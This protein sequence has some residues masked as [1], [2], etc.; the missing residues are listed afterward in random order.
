[1]EKNRKKMRIFIFAAIHILFA[2][3]LLASSNKNDEF[4]SAMNYDQKVLDKSLNIIS[5]KIIYFG[6]QSVGI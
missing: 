6:H 3:I 5:K 1:M 4:Q 2:A